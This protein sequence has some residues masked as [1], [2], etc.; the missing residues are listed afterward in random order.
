MNLQTVYSQLFEFRLNV[1]ELY[2][3][4]ELKER[5]TLPQILELPHHRQFYTVDT[6]AC[7]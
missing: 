1:V 3:F 6:D 7:D 4:Q 5:L 2:V